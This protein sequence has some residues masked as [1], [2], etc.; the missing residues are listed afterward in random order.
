METSSTPNLYDV[1]HAVL[2]K[3][4]EQVTVLGSNGLGEESAEYARLTEFR[5]K[6]YRSHAPYLLQAPQAAIEKALLL[7]RRSEHVIAVD[8]GGAILGA[9]RITTPPF[10]VEALL[11][12]F[13]TMKDRYAGYM[14][15]SRFAVC[16][17]N[18]P[19]GL[20]VQLMAHGVLRTLERGGRGVL[21]ICRKGPD[22]LFKRFGLAAHDDQT[23][24]IAHR[25]GGYRFM[26]GSH[27]EIA[28]KV[29]LLVRST[30]RISLGMNESCL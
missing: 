7:D 4:I 8:G 11:P 2:S 15:F 28:A 16:R 19:P 5:E 21:A 24:E 20:S 6:L 29:G 3:P 25:G 1:I 9:L 26:I 13:N 18:A 23:Y 27:E 22:R 12:E 10:E 17:E 14:E 30:E